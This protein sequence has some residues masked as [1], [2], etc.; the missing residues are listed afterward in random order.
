[1]AYDRPRRAL[2]RAMY[3]GFSLLGAL[4]AM[5][6]IAQSYPVKPVRVIIPS[7][8]GS[9]IDR[10][11]RSI[12]ERV[13]AAWGQP[14]IVENRVGGASAVGTDFVA[15]SPPDGYTVLLGF[16]SIV[17]VP[18][19]QARVPYDIE[20]DLLPVS[21]I[22]YVP[23]ALAVRADS[24]IKSVAELLAA[25]K[26]QTVSYGT[27]GNGSTPHIY[28][29]SLARGAGVPLTHVPYKGEALALTDVLGGQ[30]QAS[31]ASLGLLSAHHRG[32]KVRIL[33]IASL[34][35]LHTLPD[36]PTFVEL[37]HPQF[38][39]VSWSGLLVPAGTPRPVI[40]RLNAEFNRALAI[41]E[42]G[43]SLADSGI[44]PVGTTPEAFGETLKADTARWRKMIHETGI[45]SN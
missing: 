12:A 35:R 14:V 3:L 17:Q 44:D 11:G 33:A 37:G 19:L 39:T 15:K 32:G 22:A 28:G 20:R 25:A 30:I 23:L 26:T 2:R 43:K 5:N 18:I 10:M 27:F 21:M 40:D 4:V 8:A 7:A 36:I 16:T 38:G 6:A 29:E 9:G 34:K 13:G 41:P 1:M 31:W 24:P 42:I 45:T